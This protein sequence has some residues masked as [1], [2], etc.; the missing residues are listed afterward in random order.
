MVLNADQRCCSW[1]GV[2]DRHAARSMGSAQEVRLQITGWR[3]SVLHDW[4]WIGERMAVVGC[5][6]DQG[7]MAV[8]DRDTPLIKPIDG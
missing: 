7:V 4:N 3:E 6:I 1:L 2:I 5:E 8:T